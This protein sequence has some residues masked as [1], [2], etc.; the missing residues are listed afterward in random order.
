MAVYTHFGGMSGLVTEI[1]HEGFARLYQHMA[2]VTWTD[3]PVADMATLGRAYRRNAQANPHLYTVMFGGMAL[4]GFSVTGPDHQH[5]R[6]TLVTVV[7]CADRCIASGRFRPADAELV[8]HQMWNATHGLVMLEL[9]Q[10]LV[11][12]WDAD[13]CFEAQLVGLM[14]GAGDSL[15]AATASVAASADRLAIGEPMNSSDGE[16]PRPTRR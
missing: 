6:Y 2:R 4:R 3:D 14:V 11:E 7:E 5:G 10:Y 13:R 16:A 1:V 8:A 12:P 9:G 15:A